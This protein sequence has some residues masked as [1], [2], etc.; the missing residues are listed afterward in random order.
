MELGQVRFDHRPYYIIDLLSL[1]SL[2]GKNE[3]PIVSVNS[4]NHKMDYCTICMNLIE[5]PAILACGHRFCLH[6]IALYCFKTMK[7]WE[8]EDN[9]IEEYPIALASRC[10]LCREW[11]LKEDH[12]HFL[13]YAKKYK[14]VVSAKINLAWK[15]FQIQFECGLQR[16]KQ[17]ST[18]YYFT[19]CIQIKQLEEEIFV[20]L[21]KEK[22]FEDIDFFLNCLSSNNDE[23]WEGLNITELFVCKRLNYT[24][25]SLNVIRIYRDWILRREPNIYFYH[26]LVNAYCKIGLYETAAT[27]EQKSFFLFNKASS[28]ILIVKHTPKEELISFIREAWNKGLLCSY[29]LYEL[30]KQLKIQKIDNLVNTVMYYAL[31]VQNCKNRTCECNSYFINKNIKK[32]VAKFMKIN[33]LLLI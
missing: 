17:M 29:Y 5:E 15:C 18:K 7:S 26:A 8:E 22:R 31:S 33:Q 25:L 13:N 12:M 20:P 11:L 2:R 6:C 10:P 19:D 16:M 27:W 3:N 1:D 21:S 30:I 23:E 14:D 28:L 32:I 24:K 9:W 4:F